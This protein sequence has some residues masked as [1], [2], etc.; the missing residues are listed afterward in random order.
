[1]AMMFN[2][3]N[4]IEVT[5][6]DLTRELAD[7]R[8]RCRQLE[9]L[10]GIGHDGVLPSRNEV[11]ARAETDAAII[12][13]HAQRLADRILDQAEQQARELHRSTYPAERSYTS[14]RPYPAE[15]AYPA[16][17]AQLAP[18]P[19]PTDRAQLVPRP[20][21]APAP[22][23]PMRPAP[24]PSPRSDYMSYRD[25]R[26]YVD[27]GFATSANHH[28]A[29]YG[30]PDNHGANHH[31]ATNHGAYRQLGDPS[32]YR[33]REG[34]AMPAPSSSPPSQI[35]G[36]DWPD[37][38]HVQIQASVGN[39]TW[40]GRDQV[41]DLWDIAPDELDASIDRFMSTAIERSHKDLLLEG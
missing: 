39:E 28:G 32:D 34:Y 29:N 15:R 4:S 6:D 38:P 5:I 7:T 10:L 36:Y 17:Q 16:P 35:A 18:M 41:A 13:V 20:Q 3:R 11:I 14:E 27:D 1:M 25:P 22:P 37:Q 9:E 23:A 21:V 19:S 26:D 2:K 30:G 8:T 24:A 31:G 33:A 12:R 40:A